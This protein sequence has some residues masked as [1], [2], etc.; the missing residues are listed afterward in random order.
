MMRE[1]S[2][3]PAAAANAGVGEQRRSARGV[4]P[5]VDDTRETSRRFAGAELDQRKSSRLAGDGKRR[6]DRGVRS[7]RHRHPS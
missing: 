5:V 2:D 3:A 4:R 1:E 7:A 6:M